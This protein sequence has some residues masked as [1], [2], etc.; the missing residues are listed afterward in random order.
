MGKDKIQTFFVF[1]VALVFSSLSYATPQEECTASGGTWAAAASTSGNSTTGTCTCPPTHLTVSPTRCDTCS[2]AHKVPDTSRSPVVSCKCAEGFVEDS[3]RNCLSSNTTVSDYNWVS[4]PTIIKTSQFKGTNNAACG[5]SY[6]MCIGPAKLKAD[7]TVRRMIKCFIPRNSTEC[8]STIEPL[9]GSNSGCAFLERLESDGGSAEGDIAA[10]QAAINSL[11]TVVNHQDPNSASS[12]YNCPA[13]TEVCNGTNDDFNT[14][15]KCRG[16]DICAHTMSG[17][18]AL[19]S[20]R[21]RTRLEQLT[22][23]QHIR[24]ATGATPGSLSLA[25]IEKCRALC[26]DGSTVRNNIDACA[27]LPPDR[28]SLLTSGTVPDCGDAISQ[29][30]CRCGTNTSLN[31]GPGRCCEGTFVAGDAATCP[32]TPASTPASTPTSACSANELIEEG[33]SCDCGGSKTGPGRC[34]NGAWQEGTGPCATEPVAPPT[35]VGCGSNPGCG[36]GWNA[37]CTRSGVWQCNC[38]STSSHYV[39]VQTLANGSSQGGS[40]VSRGATACPE[41]IGPGR[42]GGACNADGRTGWLTTTNAAGEP[43]CQC[44]YPSPRVTPLASVSGS[45]TLETCNEGTLLGEGFGCKCGTVAQSGPGR[46]C[47]GRWLRPSGGNG[48]PECTAEEPVE[49]I[50]GPNP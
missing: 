13:N 28:L 6:E 46:C 16:T 23:C 1:F 5:T 40:H 38:E 20:S 44:P 45:C 21:N 42:V 18:A 3:L 25:D 29:T 48:V 26:V 10:R 47:S 35:R 31:T 15:C 36:T 50:R 33:A 9:V 34:C 8:P 39:P 49:P 41:T 24:N 17:C 12:V 7:E 22:G 19:T 43:A 32:A 11:R 4:M 14:V 2:G 30:P 27:G 37:I